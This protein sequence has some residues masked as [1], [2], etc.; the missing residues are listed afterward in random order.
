MDLEL[1]ELRDE[2]A[3]K[4]LRGESLTKVEEAILELINELLDAAYPKPGLPQEVL[5]AMEE[6]KRLRE[7]S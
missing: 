6:V 5:D 7:A 3:L 4:K 1:I 2:I